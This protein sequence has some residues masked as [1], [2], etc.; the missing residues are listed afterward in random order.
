M[1]AET[2]GKWTD[3]ISG[4]GLE[5]ADVFDQGQEEYKPGISQVLSV[6]NGEGAQRN[7]T[8]KTGASRLKK[9]DDGDNM[10]EGTR[11]KTYTTTAVYNNYGEYIEMTSNTIVDHDYQEELDAMRDLSAAGNFSQ[12][13]SGMQIFNGGFS[14]VE[15]VNDYTINWYE[16]G[17]PLYSTVHP[18]TVP[19]AS[20]NSN[21]SSTG[22]TFG[23][24]N[25]ET[26]QVAMIEQKT[27]D[28]K[29]ISMIGK[30]TLIV[31]PALRREAMEET[32]SE[33]NPQIDTDNTQQNAINVFRGAID[34]VESTFLGAANSGS[35]TAWYLTIPGKNKL[36]HEVR[37]DVDL[38]QD[39]DIKSKTVTY[40]VDARWAN[41]VRDWRRNWGSKGDGQAY[42][43]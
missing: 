31:P 29:P 30:V 20:T 43:S 25:L 34:M 36:Y 13:E 42:S 15:E 23:H 28:G 12:D 14:T 10:G 27:D 17:V 6:T 21:A 18:T 2:R 16:D 35:D 37:Q 22:I 11:H 41:Y 4:V 9:F 5:I 1:S 33:L 26:G 3:L 39:V 40:T 32:Q 24:D 19:G 38:N 8:G 7:F